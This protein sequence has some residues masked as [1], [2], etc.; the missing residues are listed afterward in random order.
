MQRED[1][2]LILLQ[3]THMLTFKPTVA[4]GESLQVST[5][6]L[7]TL[8]LDLKLYTM[9]QIRHSLLESKELLR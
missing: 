9:V 2:V 1:L 5:C 4:T 3:F 6:P 7:R 8:P